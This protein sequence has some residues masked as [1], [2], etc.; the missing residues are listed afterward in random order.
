MLKVND[1]SPNSDFG[2]TTSP[3]NNTLHTL[4]VTIG[5]AYGESAA[6]VDARGGHAASLLI[7]ALENDPLFQT[8]ISFVPDILVVVTFPLLEMVAVGASAGFC[9]RQPVQMAR[10]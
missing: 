7:L 1:W 4:L 8:T 10:R 6:S 5:T 2:L 3:G 9:P